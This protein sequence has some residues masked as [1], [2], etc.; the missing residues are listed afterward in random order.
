M[1]VSDF[2]YIED[3]YFYRK[4]KGKGKLLILE[5]DYSVTFRL[6]G[7]IVKYTVPAEFETD[8]PSVPYLVPKWIAQTG[9]SAALEAAVIHDHMCVVLWGKSNETAAKVFYEGLK[10]TSMSDFKAWYMY[11]SVLLGGPKWEFD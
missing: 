9:L 7:N 10:V 1:V 6:N 8:G 5:R 2:Q 4:V 11:K 3:I